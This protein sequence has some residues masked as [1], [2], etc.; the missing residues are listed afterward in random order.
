MKKTLLLLPLLLCGCATS[1]KNL[2]ALVK[3]L[4]QDPATAYIHIVSPTFGNITI[5]RTNP[6]TNTIPHTIKP[7]GNVSVGKLPP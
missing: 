2:V 1:Q 4:S 3:A 5:M 6:G 7:D